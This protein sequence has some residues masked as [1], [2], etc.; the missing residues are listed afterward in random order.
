M[1][2]PSFMLSM[3]LHRVLLG[4]PWLKNHDVVASMVHH[5]VK[6]LRKGKEIYIPASKSPFF[7][8]EAHLPK[9]K[10][11]ETLVPYPRPE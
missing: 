8:Q 10:F 9:T 5:C 11:F 4:Y 1:L 3:S 2:P 7:T 6:A